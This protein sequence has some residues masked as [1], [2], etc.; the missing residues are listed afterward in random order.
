[1]KVR[2]KVLEAIGY[3]RVG[4]IYRCTVLEGRQK[5]YSYKVVVKDPLFVT[6]V[7]DLEVGAEAKPG[8]YSA[9]VLSQ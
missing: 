1:M 7:Y 3:S 4:H 5:G 6:Q 8:I 2:C 9:R